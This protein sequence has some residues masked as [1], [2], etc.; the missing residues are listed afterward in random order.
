MIAT[1]VRS[2]I[3]AGTLAL[4]AMAGAVPALADGTTIHFIPQADL[5]IIDPIFPSYVTRNYSYMVYDTL[6][7]MDDQFRPQ[8]Q[9]VKSFTL[10]PDKLTYSF[11]LREG[12][13]WHDGQ[14][15]RA[16]DCIASL[17][18]WM[19]R[20]GFGQ[21]I[22]EQVDEMK[23]LGDD[24][25]VIVLRHPFPLL[26]DGLAKLSSIPA[27]ILP[28][29]I[30]KT[31]TN[32]RIS[33]AVGSGPFRFVKE[34][35]RPG[36]K[37]VFEKFTDYLPRQEPPNW[38]AGGKFVKVDRIEWDYLPDA[39]TAANALNAGE[40]DWWEQVP[41]DMLPVLATNKDVTVA[42]TDPLGNGG[43][44]RFNHLQPPFADE[45]MRQALL[46]ALDQKVLL[47][48]TIGDPKYWQTC[49]SVYPCG[50]PFASD[51]GTRWVAGVGDLE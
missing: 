32:T 48:A 47:R 42:V 17:Q 6:F 1:K 26:I 18:R 44:M 51:A 13:R 49:Y 29:R 5:R 2:V 4:V 28:E 33:D 38:T 40:E 24:R 36:A 14:P 11:T 8:P 34:Q 16:A 9:M 12:L 39:T 21:A 3:R 27:F 19:K 46:Y 41:V 31:D 50:T 37:A 30:A 22:A 35:W 20:D 10:S 23:A 7:G 45:R 25:F 43:N 15:V